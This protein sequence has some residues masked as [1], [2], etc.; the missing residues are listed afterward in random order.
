[1]W[2]DAQT[3]LESNSPQAKKQRQNADASQLD[4]EEIRQRNRA[5]WL[6]EWRRQR[7]EDAEDAEVLEKELKDLRRLREQEMD[8]FENDRSLQLAR[9]Q[10]HPEPEAKK[11]RSLALLPS[12]RGQ[13]KDM[14]EATQQSSDALQNAT[15]STSSLPSVQQLSDINSS[16]SSLL[17]KGQAKEGEDALQQPSNASQDAAEIGNEQALTS[18]LPLEREQAKEVKEAVQQSSDALQDTAKAGTEQTLTSSLSSERGPL[19]EVRKAMRQPSDASQDAAETGTEQ[20]LTSS[21]LPLERGQAEEVQEAV[22]QPSDASQDATET[23]TEQAL[24]PSPPLVERGQAQEV[25]EAVQQPSD[26]SQDAVVTGSGQKEG[27][28]QQSHSDSGTCATPGEASAMNIQK[29]MSKQQSS[30]EPSA[31]PQQTG[32]SVQLAKTK[33]M[34]EC[35]GKE[36]G[37][38]NHRS[39]DGS[40]AIQQGVRSSKSDRLVR[41]A[42]DQHQ[43]KQTHLQQENRSSSDGSLIRA[44][45]PQQQQQ[46]Q[47]RQ[48]SRSVSFSLEELQESRTWQKLGVEP[49]ERESYLT[50]ED[51]QETF[52]MDKESFAKLP[53]WKRDGLKRKALLF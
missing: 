4:D 42:S 36:A 47:P 44:D 11:S 48:V 32:A 46:K 20:A 37:L 21:P 49:T 12:K 45:E 29:E 7:D 6:K 14:E 41:C 51:F 39:G 18:S 30:K 1:V 35:V 24:T 27:I 43:H 26:A 15:A 53:K 33:K 34:P 5:K 3:W 9:Q 40:T 17:L 25:K 38:K 23:G 13:A 31:L 52:K 8:A 22:Q 28:C 10:K 50:P 2:K 19:A 16:T